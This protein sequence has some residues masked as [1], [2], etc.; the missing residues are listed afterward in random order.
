[1]S[2]SFS[3]EFIITVCVTQ[4]FWALN[5]DYF[6]IP[7]QWVVQ[8]EV[9]SSE[10]TLFHTAEQ[11]FPEFVCVRLCCDSDGDGHESFWDDK[12]YF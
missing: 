10:H 7:A 1:M 3:P 5:K 8:N 9:F 12:S 2:E 11:N 6:Y 4:I